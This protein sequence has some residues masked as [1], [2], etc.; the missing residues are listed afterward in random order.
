M[1]KDAC[2]QLQWRIQRTGQGGETGTRGSRQY[3]SVILNQD[4]SDGIGD[5]GALKEFVYFCNKC[6]FQNDIQTPAPPIPNNHHPF[7]DSVGK[8]HSVSRYKEI[9]LWIHYALKKVADTGPQIYVHFFF[10]KYRF[11]EIIVK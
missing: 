1:S 6:L 9:R 2:S 8:R 5:G 7:L 10:I 4:L 11:L 3:F